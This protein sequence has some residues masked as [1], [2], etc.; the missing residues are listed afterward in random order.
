MKEHHASD[1]HLGTDDTDTTDTS[2]YLQLYY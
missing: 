2:Y 1:E